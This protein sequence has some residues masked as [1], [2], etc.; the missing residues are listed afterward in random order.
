MNIKTLTYKVIKQYGIVLVLLLIILYFSIANPAFAK[1]SNFITITRHMTVVC[2]SGIGMLFV[3]VTGGIDLSVGW[4]MSATA[5]MAGYFMVNMKINPLLSCVMIFFIT[6]TI[7]SVIGGIIS[8]LRIAPFIVTMSFMNILRGFSYLITGGKTIYG[9]PDSFTFIGNGY[10]PIILMIVAL[11]IG[12]FILRV[13][14]FGR[15]YYALGS[16]EE[17]ARLSGLNVDIIKISAYTIS[18]F[19]ATFAGL[20]LVSR[21]KTAAAGIGSGYEFDVITACVLGGVGMSG[22]VG[23]LYH[24][25]VGALIIAVINNGLI[26]MQV[27][28]F[29]QLVLKG[30]ILLFAVIYDRKQQLRKD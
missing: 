27:S 10:Y 1:M 11:L 4:M 8:K 3:L 2:I 18:S 6:M 29:V 21:I 25:F 5:M 26:I 23:K 28:E 24:V 22:S 30:V 20:I 9:L 7:G 15:Y 16:N 13:T 19:F 14:Y 17:A 12:W